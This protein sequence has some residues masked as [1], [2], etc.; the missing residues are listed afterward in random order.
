[1]AP[2]ATLLDQAHGGDDYAS[3]LADEHRKLADPSLTPSARIL[4]TMREQEIPFFRLAMNC[5][6]AWA[7]QFREQ[8]LPAERHAYYEQASRQS[9]TD[10]RAAEAGDD[11]DF[12]A[13]LARYYEQY[14]ALKFGG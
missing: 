11:I 3:V 14:D 5:S 8:P 9:E 1:M 10:Q 6:E 12:E 7:Q 2:L 4:A 13:Y